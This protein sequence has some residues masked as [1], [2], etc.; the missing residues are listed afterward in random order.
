MKAWLVT[1]DKASEYVTVDDSIVSILHSRLS[2]RRVGDFI[3]QLYADFTY[4]PSEKLARL[5]N[6]KLNLYQAQ[7]S[8]GGIV[9]CGDNPFLYARI[10]QNLR[11]D[12]DLNGN[13]TL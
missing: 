7:I 8:D 10:V 5:R 4:T 3:E 1:W 2:P 13:Q 12:T 9:I 6:K 11:V